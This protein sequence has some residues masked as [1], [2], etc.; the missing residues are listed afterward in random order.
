MKEGAG[1][2]TSWL[3]PLLIAVERR[4]ECAGTGGGR[5]SEKKICNV[6]LLW[7]FSLF[8]AGIAF[9]SLCLGE[10][11][12]AEGM[13]KSVGLEDYLLQ[14][15]PITI[16]HAVKNVSG[17]TYSLQTET[18]FLICNRP[19]QI[20]ELD[21]QGQQQRVIDLQG[22]DDTEGIAHIR[23]NLFAVLEE[24][25]RTIC[26]IEIFPAA[27]TIQRSDIDD[28]TVVDSI[29]AGNKGLEGISYDPGGERFYVVKEKSPRKLY[30]VPWPATAQ[31]SPNISEP[32]DIQ[33]D[34]LSLTD[35]SGVYYHPHTGNL[36]ILSD[37]SA[38]VAE[39]T[40][41]GK[42]ISRLSLQKGGPGGLPKDVPQA[43]GITMHPNGML[44]IC[45][46][47]DLFYRFD[48]LR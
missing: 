16:G 47:P 3:Q 22:F 40:L 46:E 27:T 11:A 12:W 44:F 36:L 28:I 13:G 15:G 2:T 43:E 34:S 25:R 33:A 32:W 24:Q 8:A 20:I 39:V 10:R 41:T 45:S 18:L 6:N 14:A 21:L 23:G 19:T 37:D 1:G 29:P 17:L 4:V 5:R 7:V 26:I 9:L 48:R 31:G 30:Q 38:A 35:L 42:E